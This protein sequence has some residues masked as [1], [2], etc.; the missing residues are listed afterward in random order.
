[1]GQN[2]SKWVGLPGSEW[3]ATGQIRLDFW[4]EPVS[5]YRLN[6]CSTWLIRRGRLC[7][8]DVIF[9]AID[10]VFRAEHDPLPRIF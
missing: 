1:M 3:A 10:S 8:F 5:V 7:P 9:S 4:I 2:G 6:C